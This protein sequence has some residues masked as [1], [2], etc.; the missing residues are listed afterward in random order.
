[1]R[2]IFLPHFVKRAFTRFCLSHETWMILFVHL[3]DA[4]PAWTRFMLVHDLMHLFTPAWSIRQLSGVQK[5]KMLEKY[6]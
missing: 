2:I 4:H 3:V 1:M 6:T 5:Q